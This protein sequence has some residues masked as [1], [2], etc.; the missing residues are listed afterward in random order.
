MP[1]DYT[2]LFPCSPFQ[3]PPGCTKVSP[4]TFASESGLAGSAG[5]VTSTVR[6]STAMTPTGRPPSLQ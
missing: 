1:K 4:H 5:T 6:V 2:K 3:P